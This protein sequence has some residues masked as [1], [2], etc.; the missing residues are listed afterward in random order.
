VIENATVDNANWGYWLECTIPG[1]TFWDNPPTNGIYGA[2][3][4]YTITAAKG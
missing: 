4:I 1:V 2:D 3:V